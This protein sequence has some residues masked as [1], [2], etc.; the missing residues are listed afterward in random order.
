MVLIVDIENEKL[1]MNSPSDELIV[2]HQKQ[3]L[4]GKKKNV[5]VWSWE[6]K[7]V[8]ILVINSHE[9][10]KNAARWILYA[11]NIQICWIKLWNCNLFYL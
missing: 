1:N 2:C 3:L 6:K 5:F 11:F 4:F 9:N 10:D 7:M 8:S